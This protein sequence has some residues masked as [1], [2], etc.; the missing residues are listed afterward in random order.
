M[1]GLQK[2]TTCQ[3]QTQQA[4][5]GG[6]QNLRGIHNLGI[7]PDLSYMHTVTATGSKQGAKITPT[8]FDKK[9]FDGASP[10]LLHSRTQGDINLRTGLNFGTG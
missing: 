2:V 8:G 5:A 10:Q 1:H 6:S 4:Y 3:A 7:T 9:G